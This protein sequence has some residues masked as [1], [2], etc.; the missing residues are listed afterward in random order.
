MPHY[1]RI[2][3]DYAPHFDAVEPGAPSG[4][5]FL[6]NGGQRIATL[7][8][9]LNTP[10]RGGRTSFPSMQ[11]SIVPQA[12]QALIFFPAFVD[13]RLDVRALHTAEPAGDTKWVSQIWLRESGDRRD[14]EPSRRSQPMLSMAPAES[15]SGS[16]D[17]AETEAAVSGGALEALMGGLHTTEQA[18]AAA[19]KAARRGRDGPPA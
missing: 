11:L 9:Y 7:L 10:A 3:Q 2:S 5:L 12:G 19:A 6:A 18:A 1:T 15:G 16:D 13:G 8:V 17:G 14:A 4:R